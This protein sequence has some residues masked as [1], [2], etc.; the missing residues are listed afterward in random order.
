MNT[1]MKALSLALFGLA[2]YAFAGSAFAQCPTS[3]SP[4]WA[5]VQQLGGGTVASVSGGLDGSACKME[6][7][8]T[9][10]SLDQATVRDDTPANETRYRF[11]FLFNPASVAPTFGDFDSVVLFSANSA[12]GFPTGGSRQMLRVVLAK[13]AAGLRL[14]LI[15]ACNN[16]GTA[17]RC[18][19]TTP[20]LVAGV[21]RIE[22]DLKVGSGT[23][24]SMKYWLNAA[25]GTTEPG[26]TGQYPTGFDNSGWV[27][28]KQALLGLTTPSPD[29]S[30]NQAGKSVFF[31]A[32]DSRR[33]TYIGS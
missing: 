21:N 7:K 24:G 19:T 14:T 11:Q 2:G 3:L 8:L 10:D 18:V 5:A 22:V 4:P 23:A 31:D 20:D 32:F 27:G 6:A 28:V 30:T 17:N 12:A 26:A 33:S 9:N 29:Y 13:S 15:S 1:K 16:P 25:V